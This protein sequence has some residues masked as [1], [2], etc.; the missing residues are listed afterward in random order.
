M[1]AHKKVYIQ[2]L[3]VNYFILNN[4]S[5]I[6][7][8]PGMREIGLTDSSD[9]LEITFDKITEL[10]TECQFSDCTH[11][12]EKNCAILN[13]IDNG[14]L[15]RSQY[16]NYIKMKQ[17][18]FH[19]QASVVEK[20]KRDKEFGKMIKNVMKNKK[21]KRN[22]MLSKSDIKLIRSLDKKKNR[23]LNQLYV[24]EGERLYLKLFNLIVAK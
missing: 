3:I 5:L 14:S 11:T 17:E 9:A 18:Q 6:I 20:R 23:K 4:G 13:A 7:D 15:E 8:N 22:K 24:I 10:S 1:R 19:F 12:H 21:K 16:D 2:P